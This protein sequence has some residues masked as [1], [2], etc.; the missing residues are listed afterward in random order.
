MLISS[1]LCAAIIDYNYKHPPQTTLRRTETTFDAVNDLEGITANI[2]A[3][4]V[5]KTGLI[6]ILKNTTPQKYAYDGRPWFAVEEK[7]NGKWYTIPYLPY[8]EG[9]IIWD[10]LDEYSTKEVEQGWIKWH[11]G[12]G[13]GNYRILQPIN[14]Y[15][16]APFP[17]VGTIHYVSAEF[18]ID[19]YSNS[20]FR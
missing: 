12:L 2:K 9:N 18:T 3:N 14:P 11:A 19:Q 17:E 1:F 4:T 7:I 8:N 16:E 6:L 15:P 5:S 20:A 13:P 10:V